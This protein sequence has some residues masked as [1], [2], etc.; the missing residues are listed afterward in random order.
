MGSTVAA[1]QCNGR[2]TPLGIGTARPRLRWR[3]EAEG[4]R[5]ARQVRYHLQAYAEGATPGS[6]GAAIWDT[7]WVES[8]DPTGVAWDG[9]PLASQTQY[10]WRVR[11]A[12]ELGA[13]SAW[14]DAT[15]FETGLLDAADWTADW[16]EAGWDEPVGERRP[17]AYLRR[18]FDVPGEIRRARLHA[19]ARGVY[20]LHLNGAVVG[21]QVLRP[22]W[23]M[24]ED[25]IEYQTYDVT[26]LLRPGRNVVAAVVGDGKFRGKVLAISLRDVYGDR[27]SLLAQLE[28]EL[29]DGRRIVVGT[30]ST[31]RSAEGPVRASDPKD[32][33]IYDAQREQV[34]WDDVGFDDAHWQAVR[35]GAPTAARLVAAVAPPIVRRER[36]PVAQIISTP[37]GET[38]LDFGQNL[39]GR[40]RFHVTGRRGRRIVLTHGEML[41]GDGNFTLGNLQPRGLDKLQQRDEYTLRGDPDGESYEPV[42]AVHGFRYVKLEGWPGGAPDPGAFEAIAVYTDLEF[43]NTFRCSEPL[44]EQLH[45]NITWSMRSNFGDVPTDCPTREQ[46]G[47]TGDA[48]VFAPTAAILADVSGFFSHW[49]EDLSGEQRRHGYVPNMIPSP[50]G[51][52]RLSRFGERTEGGAGWGDAAVLVPWAIYRAY[53]DRDLLER[54][55]P[56]MRA[57]VEHVRAR[58]ATRRHW[59]RRLR[60]RTAAPHEQHLWDTGFH[61][62]EWSEPKRP[63]ALFLEMFRN[64]LLSVPAVATAFFAHSASVL[65]D[66]AHELGHEQDAE[67]YRTLAARVRTAWAAEF[68][69]PDGRLEPDT[70]ATY[71]RALAFRLVPDALRPQVVQRLVELIREADT[72][73]GT[74]FL[75]TPHLCFVLADDGHLDLAYELLLQ[76]T[77]PS[78]LYAVT[79]GA[80]TVWEN[81]NSIKPD[82]TSVFSLNHYSYG[83][84]GRFLYERVAGLRLDPSTPGYRTFVVAPTPGGG[85]SHASTSLTTAFGSIECGWELEDPGAIT[86]TA[87]VPPG[88]AATVTLPRAAE[89]TVLDHGDPLETIDLLQPPRRTEDGLTFVVGPGDYRFSYPWRA[90]DVAT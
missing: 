57:W 53:G 86:V 56:S 10:I 64:G 69:G 40:V 70:Q 50:R 11:I 46:A 17:A 36:F 4:R 19:T 45:R 2:T 9:P 55:Y 18:P 80:T 37:A 24:F 35:S 88:T 34:G 21:D 22:R 52:S 81:W 48:Q 68:I 60:R 54:Q 74:G 85:L 15:W 66:A 33:E 12:D 79:Q 14:S 72:H 73:L 31:W 43:T 44:L 41:D 30:D 58:A 63:S 65:A 5:G 76:T 26:D 27:T 28:I 16:I 84:I 51:T 75:A 49:L 25:R 42:F 77:P 8:V 1:L 59:T 23:T 29:V 87:S 61:F 7:G 78:W 20:E 6:A 67:A 62:G 32:G 89:G 82:G 83:A 71:V 47:W 38:V 39:A 13:E 3:I 90:A